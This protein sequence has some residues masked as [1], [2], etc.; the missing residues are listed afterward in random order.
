MFLNE[1]VTHVPISDCN[2]TLFILGYFSNLEQFTLR[3]ELLV[4]QFAHPDLV[5]RTIHLT[6][7]AYMMLH[8]F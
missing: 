5:N 8:E 6:E 2:D 3:S 7:N 1:F 4:A